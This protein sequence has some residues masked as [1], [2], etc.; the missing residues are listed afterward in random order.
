MDLNPYRFYTI[1]PDTAAKNMQFTT[2]EIKIVGALG[3]PAVSKVVASSFWREA[4]TPMLDCS[5]VAH[6]SLPCSVFDAQ[7]D[8]FFICDAEASY[9]PRNLRII[10]FM[11]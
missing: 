1:Q 8:G 4:A 10:P 11:R 2:G 5:S 9:R 7:E 3:L 6:F